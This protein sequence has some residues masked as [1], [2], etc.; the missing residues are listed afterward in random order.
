M[1]SFLKKIRNTI[2]NQNLLQK[3]GKII[4][5]VSGGADSVALL[6]ALINLGYECVAAHC[7]FHLRG[8]ESNRDM[9]FVE[10]LTECLNVDL[11]LKEF[12]I[13][14]RVSQ[15]GESIEMACRSARYEWFHELLDLN[16]AQAITV[17]HHREDQAETFFINLLRGS[18]LSGLSGMRFRNGNIVRPMLDTSRREIE[19]YL[20]D[21]HLEWVNDSS[22]SSDGF[23][24]N[25]VRNKILPLLEQWFPGACDGILRSMSILREN[26]EL[27]SF[28]IS[29]RSREYL[30]NETG[31]INITDL[32]RIEPYPAAL[33]FELLKGEGFN[34]SQANDIIASAERSGGTFQVGES[35]IREV[36]HGIL[37]G[38]RAFSPILNDVYNVALTEDIFNPIH[39]KITR[40]NITDFKPER[41]LSVIYLDA[42]VL[43]G[44]NK[45]WQIRKWRR[46]D[47]MI[48]FG[49]KASKLIS[50]IF[51]DAK[52]SAK[53]KSATWILTCNEEVVWVIGLRSSSFYPVGPSTRSYL[54]LRL[55]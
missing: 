4:V 34:R 24:R 51:A 32:I 8:D 7:N 11:Y 6:S 17:G 19:Q 22:N 36:D 10:M 18:G 27:Y 33:I 31:D 29:Q 5:A 25:R 16:L 26:E 47:R 15:T 48:P 45:V 20:M 42:A 44:K 30:N 9:R 43:S 35:H 50:D 1:H 49:M 2:Q 23:Y 54:R 40:H 28:L 38:P 53:E 13:N 46:G 52:L 14:E 21:E 41:D 3:N 39:I 55:L 37:R 12:N